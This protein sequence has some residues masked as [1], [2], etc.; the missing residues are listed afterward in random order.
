MADPKPHVDAAR[1]RWTASVGSGREAAP[2][3]WGA[4]NADHFGLLWEVRPD[5]SPT[6]PQVKASAMSRVGE[7]FGRGDRFANLHPICSHLQGRAIKQLL[8]ALTCT[9]SP[10]SEHRGRSTA[11]QN[12]GALRVKQD[13]APILTC[14]NAEQQV[15]AGAVEGRCVRLGAV[16]RRS[17]HPAAPTPLPD[18]PTPAAHARGACRRATPQHQGCTHS[19]VEP[20]GQRYFE[21][22]KPL[23]SLSPPW[24][25]ARAAQAK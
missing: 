19:L 3:R 22:S 14:T 24:G 4:T 15:G 17:G 9:Y 2:V 16:Q 8:T 6:S 5:R 13:A 21:P 20:G 25:D 1:S 12:R 10:A 7:H 11:A 18:P 23:L